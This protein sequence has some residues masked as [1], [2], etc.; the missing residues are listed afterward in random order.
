MGGLLSEVSLL[1]HS[2]LE[3]RLRLLLWTFYGF[4]SV[5]CL[6]SL[7]AC[8]FICDL[9]SPAG[10]ALTS[11]FSFVMSI[12]EFDTFPLVSWVSCGT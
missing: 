3:N 9:W 5:L 1:T 10:K 8:L 7:C 6:L 2:K 11:W 4:F 12:C